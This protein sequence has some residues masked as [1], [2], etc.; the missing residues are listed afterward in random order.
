MNPNSSNCFHH[1]FRFFLII[2]FRVFLGFGNLYLLIS[3]RLVR[4]CQF[5]FR[6]DFDSTMEVSQFLLVFLHVPV[7]T[8]LSRE[9]TWGR[10]V[11]DGNTPVA[12]TDENYVCMTLDVWPFN[13]CPQTPCVW[14]GNASMLVLVRILDTH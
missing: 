5:L 11:V 6:H 14:D 13:E 4:L 2:I 12:K 8:V 3:N 1:S 7:L 9:V 10:I